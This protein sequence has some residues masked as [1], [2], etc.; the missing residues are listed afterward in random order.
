MQLAMNLFVDSV[1]RPWPVANRPTLLL[2]GNIGRLNSKETADFLKYCRQNWD[3]VIY[4][5][6]AHDFSVPAGGP[7]FWELMDAVTA[8]GIV[9]GERGEFYVKGLPPLLTCSLWTA[10]PLL[11]KTAAAFAPYSH[12]EMG[13]GKPATPADIA[14]WFFE[15]REWLKGRL[16]AHK[17]M[18]R[19]VVVASVESPR[20]KFDGIMNPLRAPIGMWIWSGTGSGTG[21]LTPAASIP[22]LR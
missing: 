19:Q 3:D 14:Q 22:E 7:A 13:T 18:G 6:S 10:E 2:L 15:D 8:E 4:V 20:G 1:R 5:P 21:A 17:R 16:C 12:I 9:S 11:K